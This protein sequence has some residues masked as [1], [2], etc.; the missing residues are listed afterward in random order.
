MDIITVEL[1]IEMDAIT[2]T[3]MSTNTERLGKEHAFRSRIREMDFVCRYHVTIKMTAHGKICEGIL[4]HAH[5][6]VACIP[7]AFRVIIF[8]LNVISLIGRKS[9]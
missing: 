9:T 4:M 7:N 3:Q 8:F 5:S 6:A 2:K 1:S